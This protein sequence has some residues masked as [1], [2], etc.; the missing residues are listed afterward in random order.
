[1]E[2]YKREFPNVEVGDGLEINRPET[3]YFRLKQVGGAEFKISVT[4]VIS[5]FFSYV[6]EKAIEQYGAEYESTVCIIA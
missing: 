4:Q 1:M 3:C 5:H 2:N 6:M